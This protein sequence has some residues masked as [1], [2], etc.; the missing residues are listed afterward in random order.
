[1][2]PF[3]GTQERKDELYK[4]LE[5]WRGTPY[6][7]LVAV[8][9]LGADCTLFVWEAMKE[10]SAMG[11]SISNI[12]KKYG[13]IN[14]P[15]DR[16]LHSREEVILNV[17]RNVPY[18]E[19][20]Q[21]LEGIKRGGSKPETG[22][23]CCYQFGRSTAHIAIYYEGYIYQSLTGSEVL[24]INFGEKKFKKRLTAVFRVMEM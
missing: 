17:L 11:K 10:I 9:G 15:R 13:H 4:V 2:K 24:P 1:M 18:L 14:Y 19:E 3:F 6:R 23:I 7:H 22:D 21:D 20:L 12:P 8:K 5:S 16:A